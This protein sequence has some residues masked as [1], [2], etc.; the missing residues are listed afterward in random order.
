[1][2]VCVCVSSSA[3]NI[4]FMTFESACQ[5]ESDADLTSDVNPFIPSKRFVFSSHTSLFSDVRE[6]PKRYRN[7][8]PNP[9]IRVNEQAD[10]CLT[11]NQELDCPV[12]LSVFNM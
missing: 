12:D 7:H 1:M 8:N 10:I 2:C 3:L 9:A 11:G 6:E 4:Y 5:L